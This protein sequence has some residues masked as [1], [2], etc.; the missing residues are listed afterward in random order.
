VG[1]GSFVGR[2]VECA[3]LAA[4][5]REHRAVLVYGTAGVGKTALVRQVIHA[6]SAAG[7]VALPLFLSITGAETEREILDRT[8]TALARRPPATSSLAEMFATL[9]G[10][11]RTLVWEDAHDAQR[12][13]IGAALAAA[14]GCVQTRLVVVS[15]QRVADTPGVGVLEVPPLS[16]D[17][18]RALI[19][20][21]SVELIRRTRGN[22]LLATLAMRGPSAAEL[23]LDPLA[24]LRRDITALATGSARPMLELLTCAGAPLA[25]RDVLASCGSH[26]STVLEDLR[27]HLLVVE[28]GTTIGIAPSLAPLVSELIGEPT[29]SAWSSFGEIASRSLTAAPTDAGALLHL[30]R[31][32]VARGEAIRALLL[33]RQHPTAYANLPQDGLHHILRAIAKA[34]TIC[35]APALLMLAREQLRWG[36]FQT[37][38]RTLDELHM[39]TLDVASQARASLL[40]ADALVRAGDPAGARAQ[41]EHASRVESINLEPALTLGFAELAV[42]ARDL[43]PARRALSR[44]APQTKSK[45]RLEGRRAYGMALSYLLEE[46][47]ALA[48]AWARRS[49]RHYR[50][51]VEAHVTVVEVESLL[52]LDQV[53]RAEATLMRYVRDLPGRDWS[54]P[55]WRGIGILLGAATDWRRGDY[56]RCLATAAPQFHAFDHRA[57]QIARAVEARYLARAAIGLGRFTEAGGFLHAAAGISAEPG[58]RSL[59]VLCEIDLAHLAEVSG[60]RA[61]AKA[62][63][64]NALLHEPRSPYATV[65]AWCLDDRPAL[66]PPHLAGAQ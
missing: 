34:S 7:R 38:L 5:L 53:D 1:E 21:L 41:L 20:S 49:R 42:M 55:L 52:W 29:A 65:D 22:P 35:A 40:R 8:W 57:D 43:E 15:R 37:A 45:P 31:S 44:A 47:Y 3:Q 33:L 60:D 23:T 64:T 19:D 39:P 4:L 6:E 18:M 14:R 61:E 36:D 27:R 30:A 58:L 63:I 46:Q 11:P 50:V 2:S 24:D 48:L 17:G 28:D 66:A 32:E 56:E 10:A 9:E 25:A 54:E 59:R 26:A 13:V 62:R 51:Q 12:S 16:D